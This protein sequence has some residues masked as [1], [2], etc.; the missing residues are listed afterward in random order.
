MKTSVILTLVTLL[1]AAVALP[2]ITTNTESV[3][4]VQGENEIEENIKKYPVYEDQVKFC[5]EGK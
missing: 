5:R 3:H 1:S 2:A 4:V